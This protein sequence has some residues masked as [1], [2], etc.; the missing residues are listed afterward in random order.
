MAEKTLPHIFLPEF[1]QSIL[2]TPPKSGGQNPVL[3]SRKRNE[4]GARILRQ[5]KDA[6]RKAEKIEKDRSAIS[7]QTKDGMYLEFRGQEGFDLITK[8][9]EDRKQKIRLLN[10]REEGKD[11]KRKSIA[12]VYVPH[13]KKMYFLKKI[14]A[15]RKEEK[16]APLAKSIEDVRLA[17]VESF[18][19]DQKKFVPRNKQEWCEVWLRI[20]PGKEETIETTFRKICEKK[21]IPC[22]PGQI[23]FP[24]RS[25]LLVKAKEKDLR[26]IIDESPDIAE[27]R[28]AKENA[29]FWVALP[30]QEQSE[31]LKELLQ[32]INITDNGV[33]VC[34]M[35]SGA[36][37]GHALL[38]S[39]LADKDCHSV[40]PNWGTHDH[41]KHGHGTPMCGVALYGDL[42]NLLLAQGQFEVYHSLESVKI[43]PPSGSNPKELWGFIT[44]QGTS[45]AEIANPARQRVFC[46]AITSSDDRDR[47]KPSSWSG[48]IDALASGYDEEDGTKRLFIV[49]AGNISDPNEWKNYPASQETNAVHDPGQ[50]WNAL[51]VGAMTYK[52]GIKN[53]DY[54]GYVAIAPP[55]GLSPFSTTSL[56]WEKKWP[57][58]PEIV[59]EGGNA[60]I[61][62][63]GFAS[64]IDDLSILSTN[65]E[66]TKSQFSIIT[67]TSA[68]TAEASRMAAVIQATYPHA[69]PETVRGLM[70]H[71]ANWTDELKERFN[72]KK[73]SKKGD[74]VNL[75]RA[76]GYGVPE[77]KKALHCGGNSLTLIAQEKIQPYMKKENGSGFRAKDMHFFELP[78][79]KEVLL[80]LGDLNVS[81]RVTLSYFIEPGPGEIGWK[82]KYRYRSFGLSFDLNSPLETEK[83][84]KSRLNAAAESEEEGKASDSGS[85]R[86]MIGKNTRSLGSIHSDI[87]QGSA[88]EIAACNMIGIYP[89]IGWWRERGYLNR[90]AREARYSLIVSL[91]TPEEEVDIY[92]PVAISLKTPIAVKVSQ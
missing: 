2:Y 14:E 42:Q 82:D 67:A 87:W 74:V 50:A 78:W 59:L 6:W 22:R 69:W 71:S 5:L 39:A 31:W 10:V 51:T 47:G 91:H 23:R 12:T 33:S 8:S 60:G 72:I 55:G 81:L 30:N 28:L 76:C 13:D 35:D 54:A 27:F 86:W 77:I 25:V 64:T 49:S 24:E 58:K 7:L 83:D 88:V 61:D 34:V 84:F 92:T 40:D 79:P 19:Q 11:E 63:G 70:V 62:Q 29:G 36:N 16:N 26:E 56:S 80:G 85:D 45:L 4:H 21:K 37:N 38:T 15:Y 1:A 48:E 68:A 32:R 20:T 17:V 66:P 90:W 41:E 46:L 73:N 43:L 75:L 52:T 89:T 9:L 65:H 53:P 57:I 18:W 44:S 3:P